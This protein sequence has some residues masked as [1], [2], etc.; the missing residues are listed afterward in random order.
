MN[1]SDLFRELAERF[2]LLK[3]EDV[4]QSAGQILDALMKHLAQHGRI[5]IRG[6]GTFSIRTRAAR[7][8]RNP[9]TGET[10]SV[11]DRAFVHFKP[12]KLLK[13]A[14]D[15]VELNGSTSK[16]MKLNAG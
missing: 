10:V 2:P 9:K 15:V 4:E 7:I 1:R 16:D 5:E 13:E 12:G 14:V 8:S 6:F 3:P 11:P